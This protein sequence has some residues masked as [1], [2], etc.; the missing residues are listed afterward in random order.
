M[1]KLSQYDIRWASSRLGQSPCIISRYGCTTCCISMLT[2]WYSKFK[3]RY[4]RPDELA[5]KLQYT[6]DG[7]LI[8]GSL[9]KLLPFQLTKR[10]YKL[11]HEEIKASL[12]GFYT[13][14]IL[15]VHNGGHWVLAIR[16]LPFNSYLCVDP[17]GGKLKVFKAGLVGSAHFDLIIK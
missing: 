9:P 2:D 4:F 3:G 5:K 15:N 7:L 1:V 10:N 13:S 12:K 8:W 6:H 17:L 14:V 11:N 16:A